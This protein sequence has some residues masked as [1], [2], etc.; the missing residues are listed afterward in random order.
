MFVMELNKTFERKSKALP[1]NL[2]AGGLWYFPIGHRFL[3]GTS[4]IFVVQTVLLA[5]D[6]AL[7]SLRLHFR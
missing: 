1:I 5:V 3:V 2:L 7:F 4:R 6:T